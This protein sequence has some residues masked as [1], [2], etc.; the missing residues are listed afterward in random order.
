MLI[1]INKIA[2]IIAKWNV[3]IVKLILA[4]S[5]TKLGDNAADDNMNNP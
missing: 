2:M 3:V 1:N 4:E 5:N